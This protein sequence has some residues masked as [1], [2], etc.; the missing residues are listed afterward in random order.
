MFELFYRWGGIIPLIGG[1]YGLLLAYGVLPQNPKDPERM[2]LW[3]RKF[4]AAMKVLGP[5]LIVVGIV[6]LLGLL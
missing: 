1:I 3:R 6:K 4:G 5:M 2:E